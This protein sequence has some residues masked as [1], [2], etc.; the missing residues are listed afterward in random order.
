M[1]GGVV[2]E[3]DDLV[4]KAGYRMTVVLGEQKPLSREPQRA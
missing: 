1:F 3:H 2:R 4:K